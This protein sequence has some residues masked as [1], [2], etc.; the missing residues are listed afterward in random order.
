LRQAVK[1]PKNRFYA[2]SQ[3]NS[4]IVMEKSIMSDIT[5]LMEVNHG[6][7]WKKGSM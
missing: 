3:L 6:N 4:G 1:I 5:F 2:D 7:P